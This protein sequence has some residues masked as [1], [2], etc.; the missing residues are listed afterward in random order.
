MDFKSFS[1]LG[2]L[3]PW[4]KPENVMVQNEQSPYIPSLSDVLPG[5]QGFAWAAT[6]KPWRIECT[7]LVITESLSLFSQISRLKFGEKKGLANRHWAI[8]PCGPRDLNPSHVS[9]PQLPLSQLNEK[10]SVRDYLSNIIY[11]YK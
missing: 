7:V 2:I 8:G 6:A 4:R 1:N 11:I 9:T 3:K 10:K 5:S